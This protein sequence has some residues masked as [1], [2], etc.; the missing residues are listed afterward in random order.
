[1]RTLF[2]GRKS[3]LNLER[4]VLRNQYWT[5]LHDFFGT[6]APIPQDEEWVHETGHARL[7]LMEHWG[8]LAGSDTY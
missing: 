7:R 8:H 3:A 6:V 1:M 5:L 2:A 4:T